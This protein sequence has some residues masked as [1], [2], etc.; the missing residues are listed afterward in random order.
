MRMKNK[1]F[2]IGASIVV[3]IWLLVHAFAGL[4]VYLFFRQ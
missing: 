2:Y 1:D 4:V 3:A